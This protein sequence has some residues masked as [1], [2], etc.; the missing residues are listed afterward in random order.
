MKRKNK[1]IL[2]TAGLALSLIALGGGMYGLNTETKTASADTVATSPYCL[3]NGITTSDGKSSLGSPSNFDVYM[4]ASRSSGSATI[5]N[6][7]T[8]NWSQYYVMV[9][10]IDVTEHLRLDLYKSG[11]LYKSIDVSGD[12]DITTNFGGLPSG[13][14][15]LRYECR[16]KKNIFT[17]NVYYI[18]EYVF[19][20][21]IDTEPCVIRA[22]DL[23]V[24]DHG[25]K[26]ENVG[27]LVGG[28]EV[29][30]RT[31]GVFCDSETVP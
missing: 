6:G 4:K 17:S 9:D 14:Y 15:T 26:L 18:Y 30:A 25:L 7:Y 29:I 11:S 5:A 27:I 21:D 13:T 24:V 20:V 8:S 2:G 19:E 12:A 31:R 28:G 16:Y 1:F 23:L 3:T 22:I 10:A